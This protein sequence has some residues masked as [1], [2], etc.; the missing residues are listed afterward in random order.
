MQEIAI[1]PQMRKIWMAMKLFRVP[2]THPFIQNLTEYDLDFIDW[3]TSLDNPKFFEKIK[4][5]FYDDEYDQC[6]HSCRW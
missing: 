1:Q 2:M 6:H 4:N 3:S 5:T